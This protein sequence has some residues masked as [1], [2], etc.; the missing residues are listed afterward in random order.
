MKKILLVLTTLLALTVF[1]VGCGEKPE[2]KTEGTK[3]QETKTL[4]VGATPEPHAQILE[5]IKPLLAEEGITLDIKVMNDYIIPNNALA[6]GELDA[7]FFQHIP[8]LE[9]FATKN[10]LDITYSV[11]VHLEP[12]AIYSNTIKDLSEVKDEVEIAIPN[13]PTNGGRALAILEKA[14]LLKLKEGVGVAGT[15]N[16]IIEGDVKIVELDAAQIPRSLEDVD[17][18]VING[19]Y[20]IGAGLVPTTDGLFIESSDSPYSNVVAIR[21]GDE[22]RAEI[23]KLNEILNSDKVKQFI[24]EQYKGAIIPTF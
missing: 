7:N 2:A 11:K 23:K 19:N 5:F 10:K 12:M 9:D 3:E 21:K 17:L 15:K 22:N 20:A 18:A 6:Q 13:D 8:Y 4:V 14:G 16:D 24:E 1:A